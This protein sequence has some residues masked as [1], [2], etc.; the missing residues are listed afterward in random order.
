[1][2]QCQVF[3]TQRFAEVG[4]EVRRGLGRKGQLGYG[5]NTDIV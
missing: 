5:V 2:S 4:A 3:L 1:M